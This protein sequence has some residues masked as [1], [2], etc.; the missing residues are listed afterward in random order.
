LAAETLELVL[1]IA[2]MLSV[3][4]AILEPPAENGIADNDALAICYP[5][6]WWQRRAT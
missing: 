2:K 5:A 6:G 4:R 1:A 3:G